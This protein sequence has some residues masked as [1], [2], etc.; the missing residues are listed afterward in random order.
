MFKNHL[1]K[2][3]A[4]LITTTIAL[5]SALPSITVKAKE[6]FDF[7][8]HEGISVFLDSCE[9]TQEIVVTEKDIMKSLISSGE[10]T[11]Q[12]EEELLE[13]ST[14]SQKEL[15]TRGFDKNEIKSIQNY[16]DNSD[17]TD[18]V[19]I[20]GTGATMTL[21]FGLAGSDINKRKTRIAYEATWDRSPRISLCQQIAIAWVMADKNSY[22]ISS[23]TDELSPCT[24]KYYRGDHFLFS[25][26][27][28]MKE[29]LDNAVYSTVHPGASVPGMYPKY[30]AGTIM[31]S[32]QSNSSNMYSIK[33][34]VALAYSTTTIDVSPSFSVSDFG[35]SITF[36]SKTTELV[37]AIKTFKYNEYDS[38]YHFVD[39]ITP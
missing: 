22:S 27:F 1:T 38:K 18:F 19:S 30:T 25:K 15:A 36:N 26:S 17:L 5:C 16:N 7:S 21:R 4:I 35:I 28:N 10:G 14:K 39:T 29:K 32:T 11:I 13:L 20:N 6:T 9:N 3:L 8:T 31:T 2:G 37:N 12:L 34:R 24:V 23:K 33:V